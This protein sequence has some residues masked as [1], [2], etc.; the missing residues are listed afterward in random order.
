MSQN[1]RRLGCT[2]LVLIVLAVPG[3]AQ[4]GDSERAA[5]EAK[6][7]EIRKM[8]ELTGSA[9]LGIQV[10]NQLLA[11]F[12]SSFPQVPPKFWEEFSKEVSVGELQERLIPVYEKNFTEED[13]RGLIQFYQ[14]P[15]G[16]KLVKTMPQVLHEAMEIGGQ[17]GR[18]IGERLRKRL[19]QRGYIKQST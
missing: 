9:Q 15:L 6:R 13:I 7:A 18:E 5:A 2:L 8:M 14:S 16:D 10:L 12:R 17:W 11:D 1:Y 19:R 3:L 4:D